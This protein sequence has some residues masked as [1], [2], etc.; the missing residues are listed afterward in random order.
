MTKKLIVGIA[1][2]TGALGR[3]LIDELCERGFEIRALVREVSTANL[4]DA[5]QIVN[6]DVVTGKGLDQLLEGVDIAYYMVHTMGRG[7]RGDFEQLDRQAAQNFA[8]A[9]QRAGV[10][11]LIYLGALA[12]DPRVESHHLQSRAEVAKIMESSVPEFVHARAAMVI[13]AD[14]QSFLILKNLV[15]RLPVMVCPRWVDTRSQPIALS[16]VI[17]ALVKLATFESPP[18]EVQLGGGEVLR[19][20]EMMQRTAS[21]L[22]KG[23]TLMIP[24]P[25]MTPKLSSRWVSLFGGVEYALV[26][27][28]VDGL[29]SE[30]VVTVKPPAGINDSPLTFSQ[31]VA[32]ALNV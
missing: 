5:V 19:Y 25:V 17:S 3:V 31:A 24:V 11:R 13:S 26:R 9:S 28:L 22:G 8:L 18:A 20:R 12:G 4:P 16:D 2:G 7:N 32:E 1:G 27:P 10:R 14:S 15:R 30:T 29:R 6:G 23:G 21:A